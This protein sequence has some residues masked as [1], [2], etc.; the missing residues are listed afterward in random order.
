MFTVCF[1]NPPGRNLCF[2]NSAVSC[3]LN[4]PI[5]ATMLKEYE[6]EHEDKSSL[7]DELSNLAKL[8]NFS[9]SSTSRLRYLVQSKCFEAGQWTKNFDDNRQ[10]DSGE[11]ILS[12]LEHLFHADK[13]PKGFRDQAF[14]GLCQNTLTCKCGYE[15]E[16]QVQHLPEVLPIQISG[17][18]IQTCLDDYFSSKK[19]SGN[20]QIVHKYK[21]RNVLH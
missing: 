21:Y 6:K 20:V 18:S 9:E 2:T 3:V 10:H 19:L 12:M 13:L 14:D 16:L 15:E 11:F 4:I 1:E 8:T 17:Q 5:I 7:L